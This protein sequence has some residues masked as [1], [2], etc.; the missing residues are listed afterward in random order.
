MNTPFHLHKTQISDNNKE[1]SV[2]SQPLMKAA[3]SLRR[4]NT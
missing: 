4:R 3:Y 2:K 1:I